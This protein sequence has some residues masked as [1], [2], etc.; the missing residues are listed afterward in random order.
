MKKI[1]LLSAGLLVFTMAQAQ[2]SDNGTDLT[3][4]DNVGIGT[5]NPAYELDVQ[6][7]IN[8]SQLLVNGQSVFGNDNISAHISFDDNTVID[9]SG[10][11]YSVSTTGTIASTDRNSNASSARTFDGVDDVIVFNDLSLTGDFSIN[12]WHDFDT[13]IYNDLI[14]S[15]DGINGDGWKLYFTSDGNTLRF[16]DRF[17]NPT[18]S[19]SNLLD[20]NTTSYTGWHM[21]T[22]RIE[23]LTK[24]IFID[25]V[26]VA[27]K[28]E[29]SFNYGTSN[30]LR[31]GYSGADSYY[32]TGSLD[33]ISIFDRA[34]T[35][36][37][38][39]DLMLGNEFLPENSDAWIRNT[40]GTN[41]TTTNNVGIGTSNPVYELDVLG[42][43]NASQLLI[44]G[45]SPFGNDNISMHISFDNNTVIDESG[46]YYSVSTTG[47]AA[48]TDRNSNASSARSF[49]GV[50]DEIIIHDLSFNG[51]FTVNLWHFFDTKIS[52]DFVGTY[53]AGITEGWKLYFAS[54]GNTLRFLDR[55]NYAQ[56]DL[57]DVDV[58]SYSGWHMIT[59]R[60]DGV[61][62]SIFIDGQKIGEKTVV[63]LPF[64]YAEEE[65]LK[66]GYVGNFYLNGVIDDVSF[67]E[68]SLNDQEITDLIMENEFLSEN[69][70]VWTRNAGDL[71]YSEGRVFI[72]QPS[73]STSSEYKLFVESGILTEKVKVL[74]TPTW[75]DYVFEKDYALPSLEQVEADILKNGH[76][77]DIPSAEEVEENGIDVGEMN[78]K[79]LKKIEELTLYVIEMNKEIQILKSKNEALES[80]IK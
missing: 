72:G 46:N 48:S 39:A 29:V 37:E 5:S 52:S 50:D 31:I 22:I 58:S 66:M 67:F 70:S 26:K 18:P 38:I 75:P 3:T 21:I 6:G 64:G 33:E 16:L 47:T 77:S 68:R 79:L 57:L 8:A 11:Y 4:T 56:A 63:N 9:E 41:V 78:A 62:K 45:Q 7:A 34:L 19:V 36:Q 51:D 2:W 60:L 80:K 65:P 43:I 25:G 15:Y 49:D 20:F 30:P 40:E 23:N 55:N 12:L 53:N 27:E 69:S 42:T 59:V 1:Y 17:Q 54:N 14:G 76:L 74:L 35:D 13:K 61:T 71:N 10:N 44:N 24:S 28:G 73:T 32:L